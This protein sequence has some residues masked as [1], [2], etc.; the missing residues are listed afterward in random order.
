ML[1]DVVHTARRPSALTVTRKRALVLVLSPTS[2][3]AA[4]VPRKELK[5]TGVA[6]V[7]LWPSGVGLPSVM[8][9]GR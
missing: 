1:S 7:T 9:L 5:T 3:V 4:A 6:A 2:A 8:P